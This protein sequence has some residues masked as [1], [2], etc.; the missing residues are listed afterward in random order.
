LHNA[1]PPTV[2][3]AQAP[4]LLL[5]RVVDA[6]LGAAL[7]EYWRG[8]DKLLNTI[9]AAAGNVASADHKRRQDVQ[10]DDPA[11]SARVRNGLTRRLSP[12]ILQAFHITTT[13]MEAPV[14]G[15]Y[16][17]QSGGWF[18][19]HRDNTTRMTA[20]RQF[21]VSVNLN[22]G[23]EYDGGEVRFPEFGRELYRPVAGGALVFSCSLLHE[24][25]PVTRGRRIGLFT[26][27]STRG[28]D[29]GLSIRRP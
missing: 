2:V 19:R 17:Q 16:D 7:I 23:D 24:V 1:T 18:R 13:V 26:F 29:P 20:N 22:G 8:R 3:Q 27:M 12:L 9:D 10:V 14:I 11:L 6:D 28:R 5:E 21:A 4:V 15:C 25:V